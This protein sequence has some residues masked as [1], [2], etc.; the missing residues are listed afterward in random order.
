MFLQQ[1]INILEWFL[2]EH[3]TLKMSND[4]A[5]KSALPNKLIFLNI[6]NQNFFIIIFLHTPVSSI[7]VIK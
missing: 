5:D 6:I 1:Q 7:F 4:D 2:K 3:V